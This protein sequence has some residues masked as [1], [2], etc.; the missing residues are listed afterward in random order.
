VADAVAEGQEAAQEAAA[1]E[2]EAAGEA[3]QDAN[4]AFDEPNEDELIPEGRVHSASALNSGAVQY[5][6]QY[7]GSRVS[8]VHG[9]AKATIK[10][11]AKMRSSGKLILNKPPI[12]LN[13]TTG[14]IRF[15]DPTS[16]TVIVSHDM[17][18][19][20]FP[21][22][23]TKDPSMLAYLTSQAKPD[24]SIRHLCHVFRVET[25]L[26][27]GDIVTTMQQAQEL[28]QNQGHGG[29]LHA[30]PTAAPVEALKQSASASARK[31]SVGQPY[32]NTQ[33]KPEEARNT[34]KNKAEEQKEK[35]AAEAKRKA[36]QEQAA[37]AKRK[38]EQEQAA[39]AARKAE[40]EQAAEA[41]RRAEEEQAAEAAR[42]AEEEQAAEAAR[43]AE[44]EQAAE[45]ARK[46]E[47][48][49]AAEAARKA[50]EEQAAAAQQAAEAAA[51]HGAE[52]KE[53]EKLDERARAAKALAES[54]AK[55]EERRRKAAEMAREREQ[56]GEFVSEEDRQR[57]EVDEDES[58]KRTE[59]LTFNFAFG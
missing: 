18:S 55:G 6:A 48:E 57:M 11:V 14:A 36:E 31:A 17:A 20:K 30:A 9:S 16:Q 56:R 51:A 53:Q 35:A 28:F 42:K 27:A 21:A 7:L 37:E 2:R 46:A 58:R 49:Q 12:S 19:V 23:D 1:G 26:L 44:E 54:K 8:S 4:S 50:A 39:E 47:E 45:A 41:K 3:S 34:D 25:E 52:A 59:E 13:L 5:T 29:S 22:Q 10:A 38:A 15:L 40:E 33:L 24:G 43:K 32:E